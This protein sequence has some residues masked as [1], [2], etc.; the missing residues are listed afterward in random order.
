MSYLAKD[1]SVS[2]G[3]PIECYEFI[4]QHKTWRVTSYH[5]PITVAGE[6]YEPFQIVRTTIEISSVIDSPTTMD[7][8]IPH[9][10]ELAKTFCYPNKSPQELVV[11][12]R[13]VH[14]GDDYSTEYKIEWTGHIAGSSAVGKYGIIKTASI[15][16]T[17]LG[18]FLSSVFYQKSCNHVLFDARCK[19]NP[20]GF[21]VTASVVRVQSQIIT[22]N[23]MVYAAG[24]LV[25]GVMVN[26]RTG[27]RQGIISNDINVLRIGFPFF[28]LQI[29]DDVDLI[30]GCDHLRLGHCKNRFNNVE[31]YGGFDFIPEVNPFEKLTYASTTRTEVTANGKIETKPRN[32]VVISSTNTV[33]G[34][35]GSSGGRF[36][37]TVAFPFSFQRAGKPV[38]T[39]QRTVDFESS[40]S[41]SGG[42]IPQSVLGQPVSAVLARKRVANHNLIWTGNLRPLTETISTVKTWTEEVDVGG[43]LIERITH[44]ETVITTTTSGYLIDMILGICLG[45]GVQ[46]VGIYIDGVLVWSGT[47]GPNRTEIVVPEGDHF[48]SGKSVFFS[49]GAFDQAPDPLVDVIDFP[50]HVGIATALL[51]DI[52]ADSSMGQLS[53]EV[54]R[55]P[56]PLALSSGVNRI[57]DDLNGVSAL[58]EVL[59]N[60]WGYGGLALSYIDQPTL[61]SMAAVVASEGNVVAMKID[62]QIGINE[63][64]GALQDQLGMII[65]E[66]PEMAKITGK[67]IRQSSI[68]HVTMPRYNTTNI[69]ELR[70]Y[71][72]GG[73]RD[74]LE[75]ARGLFTERDAEY[76]EVPVFLQNAANISQSGR[77]K[78]TQTFQYPFVTNRNLAVALLGRDMGKISA[79]NYG[80][81]LAT[82]RKGAT[83]LPGDIIS[84]SWPDYDILNIPMEV[85]SIRKQDIDAR[86]VIMIL[87]Q[88]AF[89]STGALFGPGGGIYDPGFDV[90]PSTPLAVSIMSAPYHF[91]RSANGITSIETNPLVYPVVMPRAANNFQASFD[92]Y[93]NNIPGSSGPART[94]QGSPYPTYA[95]L[96]GAIG[97]YDNFDTGIIPSLVVD[98]IINAANLI[99]VGID[100]VRAG[101]IF[102]IIDTEIMSFESATNNGNG[103]WTLGNVHRALLDTAFVAHSNNAN[104][105]IL[106]NNFAN[107]SANGFASPAGYTP[108]WAI[109]SNGVTKQGLMDDA[110]ISTAWSPGSIRTLCPPRPHDTKVNGTARS[111]T[112]VSVTEGASVTVSWKTRSRL[113]VPVALMA[114]AAQTPEANGSE[115]QK[116]RVFHRSAGGI[117]TE[118]G[119]TAYS[120]NS[121]T[122]TMPNVTDGAGFIYVQAEMTL[123][124]FLY[125]SIYQDRVPVTVIP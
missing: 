53:F 83:Q 99:T 114:D 2:G 105:Y 9:D 80:W 70:Q 82:S 68:N 60:E 69:L 5:S 112:P 29:G 35:S 100:G 24:E 106:G 3:A 27:E 40:L 44:T 4:A 76:N 62:A 47:A 19:V 8:H 122:F 18:G 101:R 115:V 102:M 20:A 98:N 37:G 10:C 71:E 49:G 45:P 109:V 91:V 57:G 25:N 85:I 42:N 32:L 72:K 41:E 79:P 66:H 84:V 116:H 22:V 118:I 28:D 23:N 61:V 55:I 17:E 93:I 89:P 11:I 111:S 38:P 88:M 7:F 120:G 58:V 113:S 39:S 97:Q 59:T 31:N 110:L 46:C 90:D 43:G 67:L 33:R 63:V 74:T 1:N 92:S 96:D 52:R 75:Q 103:S 121:A 81:T 87:R 13:S 104:V 73:W 48:L 16:R 95:Q 124:G 34:G 36:S 56:N 94:I 51:K 119:T 6:T 108:E 107:V 125:Q 65:F 15:I 26:V 30:L 50:G 21:T 117:V 64:V 123:A 78:K 77:G 86:N 12:V 54:I 14:E